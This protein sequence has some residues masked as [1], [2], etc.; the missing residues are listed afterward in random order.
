MRRKFRTQASGAVLGILFFLLVGA[1]PVRATVELGDGSSGGVAKSSQESLGIS[2]LDLVTGLDKKVSWAS[3][4]KGTVV[5]FL[6][7]RC[8]C[9][10]SH[11]GEIQNLAKAFGS[12]FQFVG[13]HSNANETSPED[14]SYFQKQGLKFPVIR[15]ER[16]QIADFFKAAQTPHVFVL[17][18]SGEVLYQG[19][20][21]NSRSVDR[22]DEHYLRM[23]LEE[24]SHDRDVRVKQGR[25]LGCVIGRPTEE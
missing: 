25:V 16:A 6:S 10:H 3:A 7:A 18:K 20:V 22:A 14:K 11:L 2:G 24:A 19:G 23:A 9:S 15:D 4:Q 12:E 21:D 5:L 13:V 17:S 8:P 1:Q